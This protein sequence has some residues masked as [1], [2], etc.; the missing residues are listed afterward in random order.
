M[1]IIMLLPSYVLA[2]GYDAALESICK[3]IIEKEEAYAGGEWTAIGIARSEIG[4]SE[5][6]LR[7]YTESAAGYIAEK[8]GVLHERKYTEYSRMI[9]ALTA[10]GEDASDFAGY[11]LI[12]PLS[13]FEKTSMQGINGSIWAL[14]A[15][16]SGGY[17]A[18]QRDKYADSILSRQN[19]DGG[20]AFAEGDKSDADV[21][22]MALV[23]LS[24]YRERAKAQI[25]KALSYIS[26]SQNESGGFLSWGEENSESSAQV[27]I[28]LCTLGIPASDDRFVKDGNS[29]LDNL[30][31]YY[32]GESGFYHTHDDKS[33]NKIATEQALLALAA[34][35]RFSEGKS[36]IY[37]MKGFSDTDESPS[38]EKIK[39]LSEKGI[40][41]GK[42]RFR[43][44]PGDS[45]TRA[46]FA[47]IAVRALGLALSDKK[48]FSD[49]SDG[50]WYY[51]YIAAAY[52]NDIVSGVSE[53]EFNPNGTVNYEEAAAMVS[54]AAKVCGKYKEYERPYGFLTASEWARKSLAFCY[55]NKIMNELVPDFREA[56]SRES[57]ADM[58][59]NLMIE[60]NK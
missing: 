60:E 58:I 4:G 9:L 38:A 14:I 27:I 43:F 48:Y 8:N 23:A 1:I 37:D 6:Y 56:I 53:S 33:V 28:A 46:E 11:D 51:K 40:I 31:T 21:T 41:S 26:G 22:A 29:V 54:R 2:N 42:S 50:D 36:G 39:Y 47:C 30:M 3:N 57:V 5:N 32:D 25:D 20:W 52:E 19:D 13:D 18:A 15:L 10:A 17:E 24:N 34:Y 12:A 7:K 16:D 59:Y 49:V 35:K 55:E 44:A 45:M